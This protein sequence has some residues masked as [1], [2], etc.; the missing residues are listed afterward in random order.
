MSI[1]NCDKCSK[2]VDTD[3]DVE[4]IVYQNEMPVCVDCAV[5][6]AFSYTIKDKNWTETHLSYTAGW[7]HGL[8]VYHA[9]ESLGDIYQVNHNRIELIHCGIWSEKFKTLKGE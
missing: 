5:P 9:L 7:I 4:T 6:Q 1:V 3:V 2:A 8:T